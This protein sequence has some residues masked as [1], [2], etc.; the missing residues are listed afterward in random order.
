[1]HMSQNVTLIM[2]GGSGK[3]L[4]PIS[5]KLLPKQFLELPDGS[6]LLEKA[7]ERAMKVSEKKDIFVVTNKDY[8][9]HVEE[10]F[11]IANKDKGF[12]L[13]Q[14]LEPS[15]RNTAPA[16]ALSAKFISSF[17]DDNA[18]NVLVFASDQ[19]INNLDAFK[20]SVDEATAFSQDDM[21]V[22]FGVKPEFPSI[23]LSLIHI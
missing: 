3:R 22:T 2:A 9:F 4:W 12:N 13:V 6:T 10:I 8:F 1:M 5:R 21:I 11:D 17:Y 19:I 20:A 18:L 23:D 16:I 14:I 7:F 15:S